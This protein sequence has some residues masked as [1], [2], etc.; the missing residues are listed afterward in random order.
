MRW[1][2][3]P[4]A[5]GLV[6]ALVLTVGAGARTESAKLVVAKVRGGYTATL[7]GNGQVAFEYLKSCE[8]KTGCLRLTATGGAVQGT[9]AGPCPRE[10][11]A[12][13]SVIDCPA[14]AGILEIQLRNGGT[15]ST[16]VGGV[17]GA[18]KIHGCPKTRVEL[19]GS[20]AVDILAS[21]DGCAEKVVCGAGF[22]AVD[23]DRHDTVAGD[24][25]G[26]TKH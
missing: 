17:N 20:P 11:K 24:C 5:C 23:Y 2:G 25:E 4:V 19:K 7:E 12:V 21:A 26:R 9:T 22:D 13:P 18:A 16:E 14:T 8:L 15:I 6:L 1:K 3:L 10:N